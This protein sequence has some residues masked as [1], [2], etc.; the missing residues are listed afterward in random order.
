MTYFI[1]NMLLQVLK[2]LEIRSGET[3]LVGPAMVR[4]TFELGCI[5]F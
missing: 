5:L 4:S 1:V 2:A 3:G